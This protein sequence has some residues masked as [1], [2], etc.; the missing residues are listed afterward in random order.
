MVDGVDLRPAL[1]DGKPVDRE[2]FWDY[3]GN[4]AMR[5]GDWKYLRIKGEERL[6][7]LANDARELQNRA[8]AEPE[9]LAALKAAH[10]AVAE[11]L[12]LKDKN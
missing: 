5:R 6:H 1:F 9:R 10:A 12:G 3:K 2:L 11:G 8:A 4:A 7:N